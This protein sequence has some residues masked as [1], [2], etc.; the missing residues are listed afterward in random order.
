M[1]VNTTFD[2]RILDFGNSG[3]ITS[4]ATLLPDDD[5]LKYLPEDVNVEDI[6]IALGC[7]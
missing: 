6:V 3:D 7:D 2:I 5:P 4:A 1:V